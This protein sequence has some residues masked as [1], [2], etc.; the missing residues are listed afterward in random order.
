MLGLYLYFSVMAVYSILHWKKRLHEDRKKA[1]QHAELV[2]LV[3]YFVQ[4]AENKVPDNARVTR[5]K[6][7]LQEIAA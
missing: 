6:N 5:A 3:R 4:A 2:T 7:L 1:E